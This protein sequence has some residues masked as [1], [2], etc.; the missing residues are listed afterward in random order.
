MMGSQGTGRILVVNGPVVKAELPGARLY[1]LVFVGELGLFGEVVRVQGENA[2]IQVYE[3]TTG[4]K[5]GEPVVRTGEMLSAWLGPGII[6]QVY[7]GVQR[8]LKVIFDQMGRPFIARGINYDRA[9]P[10]DFSKRWRWLPRV[11]VG[12]KVNIG[13]V[14]GVVPE[15]QLIE[16][17]ILYP[18]LYRPGVVKYVAPEG[19]YTLNDDI[20]EVETSDGVVKVK[21]WHKWP[22]RR[23]RPFLEKLPPSEPLITGIRVIDTVFPIA[24]GGAASIPGPFGS[25][26]TVTIRSLML[27][28]RTQY[29]VPVLCGERGNE[30]ADALQG[31]LKL[32]DPVSGRPL[33]ERETIIVNTSNMPVAAREASIYMGATIAEYFRDQG[34]DVLLMAD[35]TSRWAEAM[36][37]VALRIGEMP[38]EEGFPAYLPTR[39]AEFYE[40]AGRVKLLGGEGKVGSLTIAAS[41]SPPGGDFTEPVTSHTLRFIGAFWP[42]DARLAYSRHYPAINWLQGFSRYVDT[43]APWYS[44]TVGEDWGELRRIAIEVL[45]REAELSEIVRILGSEALSEVEKHIMNVALMLR[46]GFLKQDAFNPVDTPSAPEKQY[47]LLRLIITYYRVGLEAVNAGVPANNIRELESVRRL[48]RLKMEVKNSDY[49]VLVDYEKKLIDDIRGLMAK[50]SR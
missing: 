20:A 40:R 9:P 12:D 21:M 34:Y 47:W 46:E 16:H 18:P 36:R 24:K 13:D 45:T 29:S 48:T 30:A 14:L 28:A 43:V 22:V 5:P 10:L 50:V 42:L 27:Y 37:E 49:R 1:E 17:R 31:L 15:T 32:T 35:S 26:K 25:G 19:D 44:K 6:G 39:L 2:F 4:V 38:S 41:V 8:P 23:P 11:K 7:D 33:L 3:D